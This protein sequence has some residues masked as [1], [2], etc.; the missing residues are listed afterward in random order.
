MFWN[1]K[2]EISGTL[3]LEKEVSDKIYK[4]AEL[5]EKDKQAKD[6]KSKN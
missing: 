5:I 3:T 4:I 2:K 6:Q 1:K